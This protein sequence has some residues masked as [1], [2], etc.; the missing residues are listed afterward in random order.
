MRCIRR[1]CSAVM[2][3]TRD[4]L[5][6]GT[7]LRPAISHL[8][9]EPLVPQAAMWCSLQ[10][11]FRRRPPSFHRRR[12]TLK[13]ALVCPSSATCWVALRYNALCCVALGCVV[14]RY[15]VAMRCNVLHPAV[16]SRCAAAMLHCNVL[17]PA[18]LRNSNVPLHAVPHPGNAL[19]T[20]ILVVHRRPPSSVCSIS[21]TSAV[22]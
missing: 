2:F 9:R 17:C 1:R 8:L 22:R 20:C 13:S 7:A 14:L 16:G 19:F 6:L 10:C 11:P 18:M 21:V 5:L 4:V 3:D 15:T 12:H